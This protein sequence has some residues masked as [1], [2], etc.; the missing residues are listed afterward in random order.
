[1]VDRRLIERYMGG[2][3]LGDN[4]SWA[5][6]F[7]GRVSPPPP[8]P[9]V[10]GERWRDMWLERLEATP[11][12]L[13]TW[14]AHQRRDAYWKH[15]SVCEDY[16]A[17]ECPVFAIGGWN[18][19]YQNAIPRLLEGLHVPRIG[20]IGAWSHTYGFR[21]GPGPTVGV[22]QEFLRWWDHWLKGVDTGHHG[23]AHAARLLEG[24]RHLDRTR[25]NQGRNR[26]ILDR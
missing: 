2:C 12:L 24:L 17:I 21:G 15:G 19:G 11:L 4:F 3:V 9:E 20:V 13:E 26:S 22:I 18:D 14:L 1:M 8:D 10:V 16:G 25:K 6:T 23:R 7:F 5:S